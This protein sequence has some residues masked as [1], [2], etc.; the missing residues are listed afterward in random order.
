M[1]IIGPDKG[2]PKGV[3]AII[4][5]SMGKPTSAAD[6]ASGDYLEAGRVAMLDFMNALEAKD[7]LRAYGCY[8]KLHEICDYHLDAQEYSEDEEEGE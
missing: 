4:V 7:P 3:A 8:K 1:P 2:K 5:E 6:E